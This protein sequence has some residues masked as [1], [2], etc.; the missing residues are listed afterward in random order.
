MNP[1]TSM[2]HRGNPLAN[3]EKQL[4]VLSP[5]HGSTRFGEKLR[6]A[7]YP[8][9]TS[10]G[11]EVLQVNLGKLCNM[12]CEHC[13]V[14]AGPDR[15]EIMQKIEIQACLNVLRCHPQIHTLDLT[16]GAPEMNPHFRQHG[17][18]S[19]GAGSARNRSL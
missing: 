4:V 5:A 7:G 16:G 12:T 3:S 9:L 2:R 13:H 17:G 6:T 19:Q 10:D 18:R 1:K 14:D 11:I 8:K 15:R